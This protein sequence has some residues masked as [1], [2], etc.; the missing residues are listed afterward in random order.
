M[1]DAPR[2]LVITPDFPPARGGIQVLAHRLAAGIE[3]FRT[4]VI[5]LEQPGGV[6]F[7]RDSGLSVRR[8]A[9]PGR[10]R[11]AGNALLNTAALE[12]ALRFRPQAT[13]SLHIVASPAAAAI[14]RTLGARTVQ[15]FHAEEVG[16][17]P[18]LAAF[19]ARQADE[20]IAVSAYTADLITATGAAPARIRF[21]P[22]GVDIPDDASPL[23]A[24]RPTFVTIA[25]LGERYKGH[26]VMIRA[27]PLVLARVPDARWVVIGDGPLR[28]GLEHLALSYGVR[29]SISFLG[30]IADEERDQW[31]RR[32]RLLA[33]PSRL[34]AG[35][36]AGEG[37]GIAYLEAG[38]YH[39]PVLAGNVG[40]ALDAVLDGESGLL[41]DPTD[42]VVVADAISTLLL[43][44]E[45]AERL[46]EGGAR[47]AED[48][49]WPLIC[50]RVESVLRGE[51][52]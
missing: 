35:H 15:Y 19:A 13:L 49:A 42:P 27:L 33:M 43:D 39:K 45:L 8:V 18:R 4:E 21:I 3:G 44:G 23:P 20:V 5:T 36:F 46:G 40:G 22:G 6:E 11:A 34:P 29:D 14:R 52:G 30:A 51:R 12:H 48:Q 41:V 26:D 37:F 17:K 50:R 16:A 28:P 1:G 9:A 10:L 25:R 38:A 7:D 47:R 31:L 32:A 24:D 2:L